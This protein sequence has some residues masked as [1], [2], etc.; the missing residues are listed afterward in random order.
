VLRG[1][2][3]AGF[4]KILPNPSRHWSL[5]EALVNETNKVL[6]ILAISNRI[7]QDEVRFAY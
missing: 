2:A 1:S 7:L 6:R 3:T 4:Q 5:A